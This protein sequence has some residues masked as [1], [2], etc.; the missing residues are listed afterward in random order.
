MRIAATPPNAAGAGDADAGNGREQVGREGGVARL[1][2]GAVDHMG[3]GDH[4]GIGRQARGGD[5]DL[6][7]GG[8][9]L[10]ACDPG[11][12]GSAANAAVARRVDRIA[13]RLHSSIA[14][15]EPLALPVVGTGPGPRTS[16]VRRRRGLLACGSRGPVLAPSQDAGKPASQWRP[17]I[18]WGNGR[19][20]R[21]S[22]LPGHSRESL[23]PGSL[24]APVRGTAFTGRVLLRFRDG[25]KVRRHALSLLLAIA[26]LASPAAAQTAAPESSMLKEIAGAVT[27]DRQKAVIGKLVGFGTRHTGSDTR[28]RTSAG[29]GAAAAGSPRS[30]LPPPRTAAAA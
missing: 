20:P 11:R 16:D 3:A 13:S 1:D 18:R 21:R 12:R 19:D 22:Q 27:A 29:I 17:P 25:S 24:L 5:H 23:C 4:L 7:D 6:V 14:A 8:V 30:S 26:L 15:S 10:R 2:L 28:S 9:R